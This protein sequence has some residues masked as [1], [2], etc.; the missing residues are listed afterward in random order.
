MGS[1]LF[2]NIDAAQHTGNFFQTLV[3]TQSHN[4]GSRIVL[5]TGFFDSKVVVCL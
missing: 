2:G 3:V 1:G 4:I 5:L